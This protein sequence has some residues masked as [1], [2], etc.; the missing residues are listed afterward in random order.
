MQEIIKA[1]HNCPLVPVKDR[2]FIVTPLID[3]EPAT[4]PEL[5]KDVVKE[6][7]TLTDISKATKVF[8]EEDRGGFIAALMA[9]EYN[10]PLAMVKW[11]PSGLEGQISI[12]FRNAYHTGKMYA[13]GLEEDDKV[14]LVEDFVDT[15]GTLIG[16]IKLLQQKEIELTD[17]IVIAEKDGYDGIKRVKDETGVDVKKLLK[18]SSKGKAS[19]VTW[20]RGKGKIDLPLESD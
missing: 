10:L 7:S 8:G 15:G 14:L 12:S 6:L 19:R 3:Q 9:Y 2:N 20:V 13:N 4:S 11:N 16:M 18:V 5:L 1:F 17:V